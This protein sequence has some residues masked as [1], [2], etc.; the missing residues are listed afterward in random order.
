M[1]LN[2]NEGKTKYIEITA[3]PTKNKYLNVGNNN[4]EKV[5]EFKY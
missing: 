2:I 4:S 3:K 5:T 1:G